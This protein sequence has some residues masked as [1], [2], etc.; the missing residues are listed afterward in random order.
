MIIDM[1]RQERYQQRHKAAGLCIYCPR[2]A[3][4]GWFCAHHLRKRRTN[5]REQNGNRPWHP[6]GPGRPPLTRRTQ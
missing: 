6:G 3:I 4:S 2:K 5:M 1:T